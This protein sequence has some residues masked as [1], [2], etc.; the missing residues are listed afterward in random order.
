MTKPFRQTLPKK[1]GPF[2]GP[3]QVISFL[4]QLGCLGLMFGS[5]NQYLWQ[6]ERLGYCNTG[7]KS[8][9]MR[10]DQ[11]IYQFMQLDDMSSSH[12]KVESF[13]DTF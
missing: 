11:Q 10:R 1:N 4:L 3:T 7:M 13:A 5:V 8:N 9:A 6:T 12:S 2:A